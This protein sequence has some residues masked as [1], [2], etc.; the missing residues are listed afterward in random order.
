M[1]SLQTVCSAWEGSERQRMRSCTCDNFDMEQRRLQVMEAD[2]ELRR[3]RDRVRKVVAKLSAVHSQADRRTIKRTRTSRPDLPL[4]QIDWCVT[5]R[6]L[7]DY[8]CFWCHGS[9][10][11]CVGLTDCLK[12]CGARRSDPPESKRKLTLVWWDMEDVIQRALDYLRPP[13]GEPPSEPLKPIRVCVSDILPVYEWEVDCLRDRANLR[14]H[15]GHLLEMERWKYRRHC[16]DM[17][18]EELQWDEEN[19]MYLTPRGV[20]SR[21]RPQDDRLQGMQLIMTE[22]PWMESERVTTVAA[23][24]SVNQSPHYAPTSTRS[25]RLLV[26]ASLLT[27]NDSMVDDVLM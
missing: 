26:D 7:A 27:P 18:S 8:L 12:E 20:H 3:L 19:E 13:F 9:A 5:A 24:S 15:C 11:G 22:P 2:M 1:I 16:G 10:L 25:T 6:Q 17:T 23:A 21:R 14:T 4:P